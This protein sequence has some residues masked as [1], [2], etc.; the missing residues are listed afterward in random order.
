[1][2]ANVKTQESMAKRIYLMYHELE[3]P[4]RPLYQSEPGDL[5][6]IL[7]ASDF[8]DQMRWLKSIGW[9]GMS[10][11]D[12]FSFPTDHG[13]VVTFDDGRETDLLIAASILEQARFGATFYIT[14]GFLGKRGYLSRS[15]L[16]ELSDAGF[17]IGC[18]SMTHPYL[19][20]LADQQLHREIAEAKIEL[21]QM[22]GRS[23]E[24]F[25]CPG[26]RWNRRVADVAQ[27]AGY[28]SVATS[29]ATA[30]SQ[31]ANLFSLGRVAVMRG[32]SLPIFQGLCQGRGLWKLQ[33]R[34]LA[35]SMAKHGFGNSTYDRIR[36][37]LLHRLTNPR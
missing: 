23:I 12:A 25:S 18:H 15:Q 17:D 1:M 35:R 28:R 37:L 4:G 33:I 9:Q 21:E 14:V 13:V 31:N 2:I 5:R 22:T 20:D 10:V 6:Y 34:D 32:T 36:S 11:T 8:E 19:S 26:G 29:R 3:L 27:Q 16:R 7:L 30:N 24:H